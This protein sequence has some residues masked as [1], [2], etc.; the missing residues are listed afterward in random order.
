VTTS[1][2]PVGWGGAGRLADGCADS[3]YAEQASDAAGRASP[4]IE[5]GVQELRA[6]VVARGRLGATDD[7]A[8]ARDGSELAFV[9]VG[10]PARPKGGQER[11]ALERLGVEPGRALATKSAPM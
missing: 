8:A 11:R 6:E 3:L 1:P 2:R 4:I 10:A 9:R 5:T 7:V